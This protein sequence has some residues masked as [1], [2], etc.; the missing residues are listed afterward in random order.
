MNNKNLVWRICVLTMFAAG[1]GWL[2]AAYA[3]N[4][5]EPA[6]VKVIPLSKEDAIVPKSGAVLFDLD[7]LRVST[8]AVVISP[9]T[10]NAVVG[11]DKITVTVP[12]FR[13]DQVNWEAEPIGCVDDDP[14]TKCHPT[15]GTEYSGQVGGD[16][17]VNVEYANGSFF[18]DYGIVT[19]L[20]NVTV[21]D[22]K[23]RKMDGYLQISYSHSTGLP[24]YRV[25]ISGRLR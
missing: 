21:V 8:S 25:P 11:G 12:G 2:S 19:L 3:G 24:N 10:L 23:V 20:L 18:T 13:V 5:D 9:F 14:K 6:T 16:L 15:W 7:G 1:S 17:P 22:N 4:L